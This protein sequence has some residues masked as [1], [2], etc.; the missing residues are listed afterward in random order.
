MPAG[1]GDRAPP[2][3]RPE[4]AL[5]VGCSAERRFARSVEASVSI[6]PGETRTTHTRLGETSFERLLL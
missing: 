1:R 4:G 3:P 5:S 6:Q 2:V